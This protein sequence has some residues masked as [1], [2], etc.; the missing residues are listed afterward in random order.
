MI[1]LG[2]NLVEKKS[3]RIGLTQ[4]FGINHATA[5]RILQRFSIPNRALVSDLTEPQVAALTAFLSSTTTA[6]L[7]PRTPVVDPLGN[8]ELLKGEPEKPL[9]EQHRAAADWGRNMLVEQELKTKYNTDIQFLY[10]IGTYRGKRH[11][12][13]KPIK[14]RNHNGGTARRLNRLKRYFSTSTA[15]VST[16]PSPSPMSYA[17]LFSRRFRSPLF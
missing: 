5:P 11:A 1:I 8:R 2:K 9:A 17:G 10:R 12:I 6:E 14:T 7:P 13:H 3:V 15:S 16:T 4:F